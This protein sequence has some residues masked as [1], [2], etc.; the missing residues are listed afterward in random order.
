MFEVVPFCNSAFLFGFFVLCCPP[1][2][3]I[4][5]YLKQSAIAMNCS[6]ERQ[7][8]DVLAVYSLYSSP[9]VLLSSISDEILKV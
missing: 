2:N 1:P 3:Y 8:A 6:F 9:R 4:S 7:T 5:I